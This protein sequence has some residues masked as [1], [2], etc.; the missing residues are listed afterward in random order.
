MSPRPVLWTPAHVPTCSTLPRPRSSAAAHLS[1]FLVFPDL[2][3]CPQ[4][5]IRPLSAP[6]PPTAPL[7][8]LSP[9]PSITVATW[10]FFPHSK[11][12]V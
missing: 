7:S 8:L 5:P 10:G 11:A 4:F 9:P 1:V 6:F 3:P 2:T 12:A